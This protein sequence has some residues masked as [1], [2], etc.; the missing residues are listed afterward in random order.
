MGTHPTLPS[1]DLTTQRTLID[2]FDDNQALVS[3]DIA[4]RFGPKLPFL[5]KVLSIAKPL[6]IQAH[7]DKKLAEVLHAKD[8]KH[9]P[10]DNHKPEMALAIT[11]FEG[12]CG[13]RPLAEI[14]HF[15][16]TI[17][18]LR[19]AVGEE[20]AKNFETTVKGRET[21]Q[22][23]E[24]TK[25]NKKALKDTFASLLQASKEQT[26]PAIEELVKLAEE[27]GERFAG[28]GGPSNTGAELAELV[29]RI[30]GQFP[31]DIGLVVM[32][33]LNFVKMSPGE[34]MY[35]RADDIHA[36]ISGGKLLATAD[37]R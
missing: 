14:S 32:F 5:F 34:A 7:P 13:F 17:P 23:A 16:S 8:P 29:T 24:D 4:K 9:Y 35:L 18:P 27:Q 26:G 3:Q 11:P 6:S 10:D 30:N 28:S 12:L 1:K 37:H 22:S 33:F 31:G 19:K 25:T 20:A 21:S 15:L 2:L 36:Y